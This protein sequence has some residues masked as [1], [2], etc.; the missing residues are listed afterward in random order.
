MQNPAYEQHS[1]PRFEP[2]RYDGKI[3]TFKD[4]V[5]IKD[6]VSKFLNMPLNFSAVVMRNCEKIRRAGAQTPSGLVLADES[7]AWGTDLFFE[8]SKP[9]PLSSNVKMNGAFLVKV[10]EGPYSSMPQFISRMQ[11]YVASRQMP[12]GKMYFYYPT[13]PDCS[14][15]HGKNYVVIF[16]TISKTGD[17]KDLK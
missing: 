8:V 7:S 2:F 5:F 4:K 3:L 1:C 6:H 14:K 9:V 12:P 15:K 10:F 16:S 11:Q 13:C 17:R